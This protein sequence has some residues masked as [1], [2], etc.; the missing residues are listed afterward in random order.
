MGWF[1]VLHLGLG[2]AWGAGNAKECLRAQLL[3]SSW[4]AEE[5]GLRLSQGRMSE[6]RPASPLHSTLRGQDTLRVGFEHLDI[7]GLLT[8][9]A[10]DPLQKRLP[11]ELPRA[12]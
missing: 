6:L 2:A 4:L 11:Q 12:E 7:R 1:G 8:K 5:D 3:H 10:L 9:E